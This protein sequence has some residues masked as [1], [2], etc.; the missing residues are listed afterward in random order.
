MARYT[1]LP[2]DARSQ[3][4]LKVDLRRGDSA[5][6]SAARSRP[7]STAAGGPRR[8]STCCSCRRSRRPAAST[9]CWRSS[10]A[11]L[12]GGSCRAGQDRRDC[13]RSSSR[14]WTTSSTAPASAHAPACPPAGQARPLPGQRPEG[15]HPVATACRSTTSS[16]SSRSR[17][18][19]RRSSIAARDLRRPAV[20]GWLQVV[21]NQLRL[22][23]VRPLASGPRA[24]STS[25]GPGAADRRALLK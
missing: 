9:A 12:R 20:P 2:S 25:P 4:S 3:A 16:T 15:R 21:P 11:V 18:R 14:G 8:A 13:C 17:S 19:R 5:R 7:A 22:M 23:L 6:S 1:G 10:S 24:R